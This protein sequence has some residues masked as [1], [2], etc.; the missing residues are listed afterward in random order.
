MCCGHMSTVRIDPEGNVVFCQL[1]RKKFG[2]LLEQPLSEIWN[3]DEL[4]GFRKTLMENNLLPVCKR[5]CEIQ[6]QR[7]QAAVLLDI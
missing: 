3:S 7:H 6:V 4:K 5:C 1:I 2:N